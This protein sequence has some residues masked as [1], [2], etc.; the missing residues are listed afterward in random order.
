M[1]FIDTIQ[2]VHIS[3]QDSERKSRSHTAFRLAVE[4]VEDHP[5]VPEAS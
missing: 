4:E 2:V 5:L 3:E 1:R